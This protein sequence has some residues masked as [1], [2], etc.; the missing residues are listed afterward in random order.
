MIGVTGY[1]VSEEPHFT[2]L[3]P[4]VLGVLVVALA[5]GGDRAEKP[6][7]GMWGVLAVGTLGFL[8][9]LRGLPDFFGLL[10]GAEVGSP[11]AAAAQG[12]TVLVCAVLVVVVGLELR[13]R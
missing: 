4:S 1:G 13:K 3:L 2:A 11:V 5:W 8:G 10:T 6:D 9:S 7:V 12:A